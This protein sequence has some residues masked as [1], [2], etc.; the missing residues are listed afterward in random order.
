MVKGNHPYYRVPVPV[1]PEKGKDTDDGDKKGV[2]TK[3][4]S[5]VNGD[6]IDNW[7]MQVHPV[8]N[9]ATVEQYDKWLNSLNSI[10][11]GQTLTEKFCLTLQMLRR[12]DATL[13]PR[14]WDAASPQISGAAR[15]DPKLQELLLQDARMAFTVHVL[16][17]PRVGFKQKRYMARNLFI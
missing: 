15:I 17:D 6:F 8:Y 1:I 12:A 16:K 7:T 2:S 11:R 9:Q 14:K 3:L 4:T 13:W 5:A 10:L